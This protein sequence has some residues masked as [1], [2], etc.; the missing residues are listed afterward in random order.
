VSGEQ[1]HLEAGVWV[2]ARFAGTVIVT[3]IALAIAV[4]LVTRLVDAL[5]LP[6]AVGIVLYLAVRLVNA[7]LNRW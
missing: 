7:H 1:G 5:I 3:V 4:P 6:V 2:V